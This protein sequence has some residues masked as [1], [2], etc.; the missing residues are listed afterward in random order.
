MSGSKNVGS[1]EMLFY[2]G[3]LSLPMLLPMV[4]LTGEYKLTVQLFLD[5]AAESSGFVP[6][7]L[8]CALLGTLL[9][10]SLFLCTINN[11]A[12]T[13][14]IVGV[15]KGV[16]ATFLGF[17]LL[18]GVP[19]NFV[20]VVGVSLNTVGGMSYTIIKFRGKQSRRSTDSGAQFP[21]SAASGWDRLKDEISV[22][23]DAPHRYPT[24]P[25][26]MN[27]ASL[28][29]TSSRIKSASEDV[30]LTTMRERT[31]SHNFYG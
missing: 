21:V 6:L 28:S 17:F 20:N 22:T 8:M 3:L 13:T 19:F 25:P 5:Q 1:A 31:A 12:L 23:V 14:T 11:S 26:V 4:F 2:N 27:A 10:L 9:N 16:M 30:S 29:P 24:S 18:G 15:L 7:I